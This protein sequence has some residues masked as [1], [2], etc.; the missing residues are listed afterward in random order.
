[1]GRNVAEWK[2]WISNV[3]VS[4]S[5][6]NVVFPPCNGC[7]SSGGRHWKS[8]KKED[9]IT[10]IIMGAVLLFSKLCSDG[11]PRRFIV[12]YIT[13]CKWFDYLCIP[14]MS[15]LTLNIPSIC[16]VANIKYWFIQFPRAYI[17]SK[18][19]VAIVPL[20]HG[21]VVV[22]NIHKSSLACF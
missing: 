20:L 2:T 10:F 13:F 1:M 14:K 7:I 15:T 6:H 22:R 5:M 4:K 17:G 21:W 16:A 18:L 11:Y 19:T 3:N 8:H 12:I 9:Y